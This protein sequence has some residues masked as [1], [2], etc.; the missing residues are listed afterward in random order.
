MLFPLCGIDMCFICISTAEKFSSLSNIILLYFGN[1]LNSNP[2]I[3]MKGML[4]STF[5]GTVM[6]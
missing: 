3:S 6:Q 5:Q 2:K 1:I 4:K